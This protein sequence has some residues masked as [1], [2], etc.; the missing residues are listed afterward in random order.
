[1]KKKRVLFV[2][3]TELCLGGVPSV[4]MFLVRNLHQYYHFDAVTLSVKSGYF[5]AEFQ[6]YGGT[7]YR[8][9]SFQY[10]NHKV[11]YPYSFVQ[12]QKAIRPI[13][14]NNTYDVIHCKSGWQDAP[15]LLEADRHGVPIRIS[16]SHGSFPSWSGYNK[17][18]CAYTRIAKRILLKH[19]TAR[20]ACS[21]IAG[22]TLFEGHSF[23]NILNCVDIEYYQSVKPQ[24]HTGIN[25][26]QIGYFCKLKNQLF[27]IQLLHQLRRSHID[28]RLSFVG[29]P[30]DF[31]YLN[32]MNAVIQQY[33]LSDYVTFL[34]KDSDKRQVFSLADYCLLPSEAEGLPLV[35]LESQ[36]AGVPCLMSDHIS[37]DANIGAGFFLPY[38]DVDAWYRIIT[39]GSRPDHEKLSRNLQKVSNE[40]YLEK[41]HT[42]YTQTAA[43]TGIFDNRK[44]D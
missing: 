7:I 8:I 17:I 29:Y 42:L 2:V 3:S 28:A 22:G 34:E 21:D 43:D 32:E 27:S 40:V 23:Q 16:H 12:I 9:D 36:A 26:L 30:A 41:V 25:L 10:L 44:K 5:D 37:D 19:A 31:A 39:K 4:V 20:V 15:C 1:M 18:M 38:N 6:S 24:A 11:L 35:A 33:N 14:D 13:L